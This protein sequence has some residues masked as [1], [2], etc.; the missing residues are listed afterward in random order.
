MLF[1]LPAHMFQQAVDRNLEAYRRALEQIKQF[2]KALV[3]FK[4]ETGRYPDA[5]AELTEA[6]G[7]HG[8]GLFDRIPKDPWGNDYICEPGVQRST[9]Y[10]GL[11]PHMPPVTLT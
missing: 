5:L 3:M 2:E 11:E 6:V 9:A 4:M 8:E 7:V 1:C 10:S